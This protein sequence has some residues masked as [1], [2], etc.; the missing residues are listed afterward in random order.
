MRELFLTSFNGRQY[1]IWRDQIKSVMDIRALHRIPL[2]PAK[3]A[4]ILIDNGQTVTLADLAACIGYGHTTETGQGSILLMGEGGEVTGFAVSGGMDTQSIPPESLFPLPDFLRTPVFDSCAVHHGIPI[5]IINVAKLYS[6]VMKAGR[7][8]SADSPRIP[9]VRPRD[10]SG[11]AQA[12][13]FSVAGEIFAAPAENMDDNPVRPGAVTPLPDMPQYVKGVTFQGGRLLSVIDLS[14]RIKKRSV[15]PEPVMLIAEIAG[16]SFGLLVDRDMGTVPAGMD[17]IKPVPVIASNPW[18]KHAVL[19]EGELI[20]LVDLAMALS[21]GS[22][23]ADEIP[24]WQ[25]YAPASRFP[26]LFFRH[27]VEVVEFSLLGERHALPKLEV[28]E[29][30]ACKHWR[31]FPDAPSIVLGVAGHNGEILPVVDLAMMFG[32]LSLV[33][34][35]W[36]MM[37]V[38]NGDFRALVITETVFRERRLAPDLHRAVPIH[39]P[40]NLMY[41]CYPD[42][43]AVRL[44]LNV[45]AISV[46]FEKS[47]IQQ[48]LPA[49]S[50]EM[51]MMSAQ[52]EPVHEVE[53]AHEIERAAV[54]S[55]AEPEVL[56]AQGQASVQQ[57]AGEP[58]QELQQQAAE[59]VIASIAEPEEVTDDFAIAPEPEPMDAILAAESPVS[60]QEALSSSGG[61]SELNSDEVPEQARDLLPENEPDQMTAPE[62]GMSGQLPDEWSRWDVDEAIAV[63]EFVP[64]DAGAAEVS[65]GYE[66]MAT[67]ESP[68]FE[69]PSRVAAL[70]ESSGESRQEREPVIINQ[71][72]PEEA[73]IVPAQKDPVYKG[74]VHKGPVQKDTEQKDTEQKAAAKKP[75]PA[76][77]IHEPAK[78]HYPGSMEVGQPTAPPVQEDRKAGGWNRRIVYATLGVALLAV[79]YF[80]GTTHQPDAERTV[81]SS[82]PAKIEQIKEQAE[83]AMTEPVKVQAEPQPQQHERAQ[84]PGAP[85]ELVIPATMPQAD[86]EVYVVRKDDTLWS[87]SERYTGTPFNYPRIAGENRIADPDL[88]FPGQRIR[89]KK[90]E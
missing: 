52:V 5:P 90:Q 8:S 42:A 36:R 24:V 13:L 3:I 1:G 75:A 9:A 26:D 22:G 34:P 89:L 35:A 32:R 30:I 18:L 41:G 6:G 49:L 86:T 28:E 17:A 47:L 39:L 65:P 72:E 87:I 84:N 10:I 68:E 55:A 60:A 44:I 81:Q 85:L 23:A 29:V 78:D 80:A 12:R 79:L 2:S 77:T 11:I 20:P 16:A 82:E 21:P 37:L 7:Q 31:A 70:Q 48:F 69:A 19:R 45:E 33:T 71:Y 54:L 61:R 46:H 76:A 66:H 73:E 51:K 38:N 4:G 62:P 15:A 88:I 59:E 58:V 67:A 40:H 25:R 57:P 43:E 56:A 83:P 27:D 50:Q 63:D 74:P 14:Q 53:P 64:P